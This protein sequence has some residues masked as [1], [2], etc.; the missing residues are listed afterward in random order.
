MSSS[1]E[2]MDLGEQGKTVL[3][4]R[5]QGGN[6]AQDKGWQEGRS[7]T[8][9]LTCEYQCLVVP[10]VLC[11]FLPRVTGPPVCL[12]HHCSLTKGQLSHSFIT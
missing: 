3:T 12:T 4:F 11:T 7:R 6:E 5:L 2:I 1:S 9:L 10:V 8:G